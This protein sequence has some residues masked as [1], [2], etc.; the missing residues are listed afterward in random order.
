MSLQIHRNN[1]QLFTRYLGFIQRESRYHDLRIMSSLNNVISVREE[2]LNN[3]QLWNSVIV[4]I[5]V[6][7]AT[8]CDAE[9]LAILVITYAYFV[10]CIIVHGEM[11]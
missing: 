8:R 4:H 2:Y 6:H 9:T 5:N 11:P 3:V 10:R 1:K 7:T